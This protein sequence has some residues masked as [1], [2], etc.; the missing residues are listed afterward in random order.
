MN[1]LLVAGPRGAGTVAL[2]QHFT[3]RMVCGFRAALSCY[4]AVAIV[5]VVMSFCQSSYW[6]LCSL[7]LADLAQP[8]EAFGCMCYLLMHH[9]TG[10][11]VL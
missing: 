6:V 5:S 7:R 3:Y 11:R 4:A 1:V 2:A 9:D 8:A 10:L